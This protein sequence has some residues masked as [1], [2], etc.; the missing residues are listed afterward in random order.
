MRTQKI[1]TRNS[2]V[3]LYSPVYTQVWR[4]YSRYYTYSENVADK[5]IAISVRQCARVN[6]ARRRISLFVCHRYRRPDHT[7]SHFDVY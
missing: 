7:G 3:H 5:S 6:A 4:Y 1:G 2:L